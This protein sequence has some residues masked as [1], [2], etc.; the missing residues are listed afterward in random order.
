MTENEASI[1]DSNEFTV[2]RSIRIAASIDKVW[3]AVTEADLITRWFG[4]RA[5]ID[6]LE[7]GASGVF[8]WDGDGDFAFRI[9]ELDPPYMIAYRWSDDGAGAPLDPETSTLFRFTLEVIAGG[10]KLTVVESGFD[11]LPDPAFALEDHRSGWD[12]EL[13]ELV[14]YL[15]AGS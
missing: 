13:D 11:T 8:G 14:A 7:V 6:A 10:T 5:T 15:E 12:D 3:A 4:D 1:V 9:E 2:R